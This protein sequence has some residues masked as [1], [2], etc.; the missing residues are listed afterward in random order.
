MERM[1]VRWLHPIEP[2]YRREARRGK[3]FQPPGG[4]WWIGMGLLAFAL[5]GETLS[6]FVVALMLPLLLVMRIR[7]VLSVC[8]A[9]PCEVERQT[10]DILRTLPQSTK[11]IVMSKYAGALMRARRLLAQL[12]VLR[13]IASALML[14]FFVFALSTLPRDDGSG[15]SLG[16]VG[17][18]LAATV[19]ALYWL[20]EPALDFATDGALGAAVGA[21]VCD[22]GQLRVI[23]LAVSAAALAAQL[24]LTALLVGGAAT[25]AP[26]SARPLLA[27]ES[28]LAAL[29]CLAVWG[30]GGAL[31]FN[32]APGACAF[33][34]LLVAV[35]RYSVLRGLLALAAWRAE[36]GHV[37]H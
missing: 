16:A 18:A 27:W 28:A 21:F 7:I 8:D 29:G 24:A 35:I 32:A 2:I 23:G 33:V 17:V 1:L 5:V 26:A 14:C 4:W 25:I 11:Q 34:I 36:A 20:V 30:P 15:T 3:A 31:L 19:G 6:P 37:A 10:W 9:I 13:L 12:Y 22:R